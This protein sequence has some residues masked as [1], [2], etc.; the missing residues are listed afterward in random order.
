MADP[1]TKEELLEEI[2]NK[3]SD[4]ESYAKFKASLQ[5]L[6]QDIDS[7]MIPTEEGWKL[8]D[9]ETTESLYE[10]YSNTA[11]HLNAYLKE[12]ANSN[13]PKENEL[14]DVCTA[15]RHFFAADM[16]V[17]RKYRNGQYLYIHCS[18]LKSIY[19]RRWGG[20]KSSGSAIAQICCASVIPC[21]V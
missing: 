20:N 6:V 4:N 5:S 17:V 3:Q 2:K 7:L 13:D 14:R 18:G 8:M 12:T 19:I 15:F 16:E 11:K 9:Q 21:V 10:K 1:R